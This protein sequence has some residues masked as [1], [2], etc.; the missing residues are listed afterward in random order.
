[1]KASELCLT[2]YQAGLSQY[3]KI[4]YDNTYP[5]N[6]MRYNWAEGC[7]TA[8]C[9]G[10]V[11]CMVNGFAGNKDELGGGAVMDDFVLMS[12]EYTT[13]TKHC[14]DQSMDFSNII[15]GEFLYMP[16]HVGLYIGDHEPFNDGRIFNV[17]ETCYSSW[18]GGGL[19]SYVDRFGI[20]KNHK[21]G[22]TAGSWAQHGK[23]YRVDYTD[24]GSV[25]PD[26]EDTFNITPAEILNIVNDTFVGVYGNNPDREN[27][28]TQKFG[29]TV[30]RQVQDIINILYR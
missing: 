7:W 5:N 2:A 15:P 14:Y 9:L 18:G 30:Y 24:S 13:L 17:A 26:K 1:M 8:D 10:F 28:L 22:S 16:G 21:N 27:K 25:S 19:L 23:F 20:R 4:K 12:D 29:K 6:V 11:H 3:G